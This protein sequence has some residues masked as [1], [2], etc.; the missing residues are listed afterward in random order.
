MSVDS[1][2]L[3]GPAK[4]YS[5]GFAVGFGGSYLYKSFQG[6]SKYNETKKEALI[7]GSVASG[8]GFTHD[9]YREKDIYEAALD[10]T[11]LGLGVSNGFFIGSF[12][13]NL[14][15]GSLNAKEEQFLK[16]EAER[17][18]Q[19]NWE[20]IE[21][22]LERDLEKDEFIESL[23]EVPEENLRFILEGEE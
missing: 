13:V 3:I 2:S 19:E 10:S 22:E 16:A 7:G 5:L 17:Y 15:N 6:Y 21:A 8:V 4:L 1:E 9:L 18:V 12:A 14:K 23:E 20:E 11:F